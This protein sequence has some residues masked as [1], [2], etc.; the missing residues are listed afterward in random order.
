MSFGLL[1]PLGLVALA[2]LILPILLHLDR[3]SES[4]P[5]EF[6]ALRWLSSRLQP[7]RRWRVEELWLL[8]LRLLLAAAVALLFAQPVFFGGQGGKPWVLLVPGVDV[9]AAHAQVRQPSAQWHWLARGFPSA[10]T[11]PP[12][13]PQPL[14]SLLRQVDSMLPVN[15]AVTVIVPR[16]VDGLDGE[17]PRL[18]RRVE[19]RPL[20]ASA[21]MAGSSAQAIPSAGAVSAIGRGIAAPRL[22]VRYTADRSGSLR[23]LRAATIAW[24]ASATAATSTKSATA[25]SGIDVGLATQP[26]PAAASWLVWLVPGE[27]PPAVRRWI[28]GGGVALLDARATQPANARGT[29]PWR[30]SAGRVLATTAAVGRGRILALTGPLSPN[31]F[32]ILLDPEFPGHLRAVFEGQS[33]PPQRAY[34][35]ALKPL[36][37][38]PRFPQTPQPLETWLVLLAAG[39]FVVERWFASAAQRWRAP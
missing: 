6:A 12:T 32:P 3:Q 8:L 16:L 31:Y 10:D 18:A 17:R 23:F 9:V 29:D 22:V 19:W 1:L 35:E 13:Q 28:E 30:D 20:P 37:G 11:A 24:R 15:T 21:V 34:A 4:R 7:R 33:K 14:A 25:V 27:L 36:H 38:G 26:I 5:T 39:L 2:A